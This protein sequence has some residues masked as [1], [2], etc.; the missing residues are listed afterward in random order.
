M[1][2]DVCYGVALGRV[3]HQYMPQ[4]VLA[5]LADRDAAG[6]VVVHCQDALQNLH[7]D[8]RAI[9]RAVEPLS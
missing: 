8:R 4:Q 9:Q 6:K 1:L 2:L 3:S 7:H 5:I